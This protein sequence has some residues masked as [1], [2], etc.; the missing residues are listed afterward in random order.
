MSMSP[1]RGALAA[2]VAVLAFAV[3]AVA[4]PAP[5]AAAPAAGDGASA[6]TPTE[7]PGAS[8]LALPEPTGPYPVGTTVLHLV[9]DSRPDPWVPTVKSREL[10]V[11]LWY[12]SRESRGRRAPYM[13]EKEAELL[14]KENGIGG[15]PARLLS[16]TRTNAVT[17]ATPLGRRRGLPLV[18]LSPGF[19][20]PRT[21][22]TGLAEDLASR[23]YVVA[24]VDHTYE[25]AGTTFPDGRTVTCVA[26]RGQ[27]YGPKTT[28]G[29]AA[30]VS[31]VLDRLTGEDPAWK[32]AGLIDPSRIAMA[33]HS[34]GGNSATWTMLNDSRVRAGINM[35][36]SFWMPI[37]GKGLSR[38]FMLLGA[39]EIHEPDGQDTTWKRDWQRMTGWKRW[40]TVGG[41]GHAS[42]LDYAPLLAGKVD[43]ED[44]GTLPGTRSMEITRGY[45]AAFLDLHLR[46]RP[47]RL[48]DGPSRRYPEVRFWR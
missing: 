11:S 31:F 24:G 7:P 43:F 47:Q 25:A 45:V 23:G 44:L 39:G 22:L 37:P 8:A 26:C 48:L 20:A 10:M 34:I 27:D 28:R 21:S 41:A 13:T 1:I 46:K 32:H 19:G 42:F 4:A 14:L 12:P 2:A 3:P 35:D 6:P 30:D 38:P 18:V 29:R 36:G 9:D 15:V 5:A 33:G 17:G 40:L 16:G